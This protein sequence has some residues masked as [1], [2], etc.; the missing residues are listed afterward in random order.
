MHRELLVERSDVASRV[1]RPIVGDAMGGMHYGKLG[2]LTTD[3]RTARSTHVTTSHSSSPGL[4]AVLVL[5]GI[6]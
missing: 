5:E 6:V 2:L 4:V 1:A 3:V